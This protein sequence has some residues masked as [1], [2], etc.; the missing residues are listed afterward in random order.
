M[1]RANNKPAEYTRLPHEIITNPTS[2][3]HVA[4]A[5]FSLTPDRES[6]REFIEQLNDYKFPYP[7]VL[8]CPFTKPG[9]A[10]TAKPRI[11]ATGADFPLEDVPC[12]CGATGCFLIR[13]YPE[14]AEQVTP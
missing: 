8:R 7:V 1:T 12:P 11:F 13:W 10:R 5:L 14:S 6:R 9:S 3:S 2:T 4:L